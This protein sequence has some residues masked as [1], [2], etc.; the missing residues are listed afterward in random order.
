[1]PRPK[2]LDVNA[3]VE[4]A[5]ADAPKISVIDR[6]LRNPF[7]TPSRAI[8]L[9]GQ[10]A[11][12]ATPWVVRTFSADAEHPNRHFDA[13]HRLGWIPLDR[14]DI[15]VSIE[16]LGYVQAADGRIVRG[17]GGH[18]VLMGM[19]KADFDAVQ[20]AKADANLRSMK[21]AKVK[22]SV[23]QST[24]QAHGSEAGDMAYKHTTVQEF[25]EALPGAAVGE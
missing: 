7:G 6:R 9:A 1:M 23:A 22:E 18:E 20:R 3:L 15:A 10:K 12:P 13:V 5:I 8:P 16:S 11:N 2:K 25:V 19:P 17:V 24:A 4:G 14:A 21:P